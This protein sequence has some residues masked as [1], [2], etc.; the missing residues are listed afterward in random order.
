MLDCFV[1]PVIG[2]RVVA[3]PLARNDENNG[4]AYS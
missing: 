2:R 3:G 1:E 4:D